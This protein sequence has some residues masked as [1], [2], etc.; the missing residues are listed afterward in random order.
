MKRYKI[1]SEW[2]IG[3]EGLLFKTYE[4]A[5]D[6]LLDMLPACGIE[7]NLQELLDENL[8]SIQEVAV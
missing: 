3:H 8:I 4:M 6:F 5:E 1:D 7:E 2:D